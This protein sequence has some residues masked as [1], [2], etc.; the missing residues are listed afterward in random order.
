MILGIDKIPKIEIH[1]FK[2]E[3]GLGMK[4]LRQFYKITD[5]MNKLKKQKSKNL[6]NNCRPVT[7][8]FHFILWRTLSLGTRRIHIS[9]ITLKI[10]VDNAL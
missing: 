9:V 10:G 4:Q 3:N 7:T 8:R 1:C 6:P 5:I 2:N